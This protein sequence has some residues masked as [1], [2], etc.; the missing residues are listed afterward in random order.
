MKLRTMRGEA[1]MLQPNVLSHSLRLRHVRRL[2]SCAQV[3]LVL[4]ALYG[5]EAA[6]E[7]SPVV[8]LA[9][10]PHA[11]TGGIDAATPALAPTVPAE[12]RPITDSPT[13]GESHRRMLMIMIINRAG[14]QLRFGSMGR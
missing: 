10:E 5:G 6:A 8:A 4:A 7:S 11:A 9:I 3:A 1:P 2:G 13:L 14:Q 12:A